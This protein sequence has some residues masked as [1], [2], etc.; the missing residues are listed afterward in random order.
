MQGLFVQSCGNHVVVFLSTVFKGPNTRY[1]PLIG[2]TAIL[3]LYCHERLLGYNGGYTVETRSP[4]IR[5]KTMNAQRRPIMIIISSSTFS[6]SSS[7]VQAVSKVFLSS[8]SYQL[9]LFSIIQLSLATHAVWYIDLLLCSR[10][11]NYTIYTIH[12]LLAPL[13]DMISA[14]RRQ[15]II[16]VAF[17]RSDRKQHCFPHRATKRQCALTRLSK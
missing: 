15:S 13:N 14:A 6:L 12:M 3:S 4:P 5:G 11:S 9:T 7:F 2:K 16:F 1:P 8:P 17:H 10:Y